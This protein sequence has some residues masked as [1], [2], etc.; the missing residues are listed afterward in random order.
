MLAESQS[1]TKRNK[2]IKRNVHVEW[3]FLSFLYNDIIQ[4]QVEEQVQQ[5]YRMHE[6]NNVIRHCHLQVA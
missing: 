5:K 2:R 3:A 6:G 1:Q 4:L